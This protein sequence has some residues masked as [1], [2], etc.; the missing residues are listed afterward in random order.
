MPIKAVDALKP[1]SKSIS[2]LF[3]HVYWKFYNLLRD[4]Y[5]FNKYSKSV[6]AIY[7]D[8]KYNC[9]I[10]SQ[11]VREYGCCE[12][13]CSELT[14]SGVHYSYYLGEC[15]SHAHT[16]SEVFLLAYNKAEIFSIHEKDEIEYSRQEFEFIKK[17]IK[18]GK[19]DRKRVSK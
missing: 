5:F 19:K 6:P 17:L 11:N 12:Y 9:F 10:S 14:Q 18:Q 2:L 13:V 8:K 15:Q 1:K 16:I 7:F 4:R 3:Q